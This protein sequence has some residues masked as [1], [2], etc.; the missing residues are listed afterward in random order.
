[1]TA[2]RWLIGVL[3]VSS[4][5]WVPIGCSQQGGSSDAPVAEEPPPEDRPWEKGDLSHSERAKMKKARKAGG[6]AQ[7]E[8]HPQPQQ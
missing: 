4:M 7:P 6:A 1:M 2:K 5:L 8:Q 3:L